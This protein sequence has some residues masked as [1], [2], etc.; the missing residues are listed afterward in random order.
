MNSVGQK[1]ENPSG[2]LFSL[3]AGVTLLKC[4]LYYSHHRNNTVYLSVGGTNIDFCFLLEHMVDFN[5]QTVTLCDKFS[6]FPNRNRKNKVYSFLFCKIVP[7]IEN[8][9]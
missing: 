9:L 8:K 7:L 4:D 1:K 6:L 5:L 3:L 2:N